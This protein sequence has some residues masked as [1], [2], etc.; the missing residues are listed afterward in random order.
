MEN[1]YLAQAAERLLLPLLQHQYPW[2]IDIHM[3][4][5]GIYHRAALV[6]VDA[7]ELSMQEISKALRQTTLLRNSRLLVLLDKGIA[8]RDAA[9]VYWRVINADDWTRSVSID[10]DKMTIDARTL[11]Q[12]NQVHQV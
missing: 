3:P 6:S 4:L 8:L 5:E 2:I 10:G 9:K 11:T 1:M 12:R 7:Q